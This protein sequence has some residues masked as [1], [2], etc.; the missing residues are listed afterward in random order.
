[1]MIASARDALAS[2]RPATSE[3]RRPERCG[4]AGERRSP[5]PSRTVASDSQS[6]GHRSTH[7]EVLN[8][9][10]E[11]RIVKTITVF[12]MINIMLIIVNIEEKKSKYILGLGPFSVDKE[13]Q[14]EWNCRRPL[15]P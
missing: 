6:G 7:T 5:A 4:V 14:F 9:N 15:G 13:R 3:N 8:D 1:M 2:S 11:L 10:V 12:D